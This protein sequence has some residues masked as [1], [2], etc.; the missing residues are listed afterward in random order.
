MVTD[1]E[2]EYHLDRFIKLSHT[3]TGAIWD[4]SQGIYNITVKKAD[5]ALVR[6]WCHVLINAAG[7]LNKWKCKSP[8]LTC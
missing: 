5:G 4:E 3:V 6:D 2:E 1:F 7:I 8:A